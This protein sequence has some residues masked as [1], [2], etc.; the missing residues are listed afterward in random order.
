MNEGVFAVSMTMNLEAY[1]HVV[2]VNNGYFNY[3]HE[4]QT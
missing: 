4:N 1:S 2:D 3:Q